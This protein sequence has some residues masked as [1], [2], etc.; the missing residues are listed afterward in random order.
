M[1][2][3]A[4]SSTHAQKIF[5]KTEFMQEVKITLQLSDQVWQMCS[6]HFMV[7]LL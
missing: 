5:Y 4:K 2:F 7:I 1:G 6:L 3:E